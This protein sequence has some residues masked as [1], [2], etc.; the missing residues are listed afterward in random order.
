MRTYFIRLSPREASAVVMAA[1]VTMAYV[2][3]QLLAG[4]ALELLLRLGELG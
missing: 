3:R 4:V 1:A 2:D